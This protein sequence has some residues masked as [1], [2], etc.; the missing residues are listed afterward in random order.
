M[1]DNSKTVKSVLDKTNQNIE[2]IN[3]LSKMT[4][5]CLSMVEQVRR[6]AFNNQNYFQAI[7]NQ[8]AERNRIIER[9]SVV[10][11][12]WF[13]DLQD[14]QNNLSYISRS[15]ELALR[16]VPLQLI[17]AERF[18]TAIDFDA[19]ANRLQIETSTIL[20]MEN[21]ITR[22]V[23]SYD[24]L[25]K[26]LNGIPEIA[27]L[28]DFILPGAT[29][30]L[31]TTGFVFETLRPLDER[32]AQDAEAE[33]RLLVETEHETSDCISLLQRVN[34]E[35]VKPYIGARDSLNGKNADRA[36]H[37]LSSL[38]ELWGH[39]LRHLAPDNLVSVW[40][41]EE[42]ASEQSLLHEG[43]PTRKARILYICRKLD[44]KPLT[45]FLVDD[46]R[47]LVELID[48]FN[49]VHK[50]DSGLTDKQLRAIVLKNDSW[51]MYIL[52]VHLENSS[53]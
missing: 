5:S 49:R 4:S 47:M 42:K 24:N 1:P 9:L 43:R 12:S 11:Q 28:P 2:E 48:L 39:L 34:P 3:R 18:M 10:H 22:V 27:S 23:A 19:L 32:D 6:E 50:L 15:I 36:R 25:A 17:A 46:T 44:K 31:Y 51:L 8:A 30:E 38:R 33:D 52:Q 7:L 21:S 40:I 53:K 35:L 14:T 41:S 20:D 45:K 26:S 37:I 29:R 16:N 13:K